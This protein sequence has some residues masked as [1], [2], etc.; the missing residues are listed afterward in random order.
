MGRYTGPKFRLSRREGVNL[1]GTASP[2]LE[3]V[4]QI[5]PGA[6]RGRP[7]RPSEY[8]V[9]LRAKQRVK[10]QYG[11]WERQFRRFFEMAR[12]T[13]GPT[14]ANLLQL[15][16]RR[17]DNAVYRLGWARTRPM[18][19]QLVAH[20]HV[21]VNGKPVNVPSYLLKPGETVRLGPRALEMPAVREEIE[22]RKVIASW[23]TQEAD[24]WRVAGYP[25]REDSDADIKEDLIVEFYAR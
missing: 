16:E 17:L 10:R 22:S 8:G 21:L 12:R 23:L 4:L 18:A 15:L 25:R 7:R 14:G 20:G 11:M 19:R 3:T 13:A 6:R 2:R 1:T 24:A 5:P 9:R